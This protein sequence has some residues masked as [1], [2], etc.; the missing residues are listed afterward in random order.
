MLSFCRMNRR[1]IVKIDGIPYILDTLH[2]A[3]VLISAVRG[4]LYNA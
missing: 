4:G 2:D 3:L 1:F